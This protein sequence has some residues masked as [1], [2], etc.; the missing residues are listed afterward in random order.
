LQH[1][2]HRY[3]PTVVRSMLSKNRATKTINRISFLDW[4]QALRHSTTL[5]GNHDGY[6]TT[7]V[8][9]GQRLLSD[10]RNTRKQ[11]SQDNLSPV[12]YWLNC[13]TWCGALFVGLLRNEMYARRSPVTQWRADTWAFVSS[14]L[15]IYILHT[16][17]VFNVYL[18]AD[19][20]YNI[21]T[22]V[23]TH[24]TSHVVNLPD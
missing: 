14:C 21:S 15:V 4:R 2:A 1:G 7:I 5:V 19:R 8:V 22:V 18:Q 6:S 9:T 13:C 24:V 11:C 3:W 23:L 16:R 17:N 20:E 10:G 12:D